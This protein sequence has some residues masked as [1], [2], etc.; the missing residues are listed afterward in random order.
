[1]AEY[2]E[3]YTKAGTIPLEPVPGQEFDIDLSGSSYNIFVYQRDKT[4]Y[5]D[6]QDEQGYIFKGVKAMDRTGLKLAS[7]MRL[8]GQLWFEDT[9][10]NS[11]PDYEGFGSRFVLVYGEVPE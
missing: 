3:K 4:V 7:Y 9:A 6:V 5:V 1:M 8:P 11:D 2:I 10:G